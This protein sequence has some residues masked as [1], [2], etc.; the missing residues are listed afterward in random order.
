MEANKTN[1]FGRRESDFNSTIFMIARCSIK[2]QTCI[3]C[4]YRFFVVWVKNY[5]FLGNNT[6]P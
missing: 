2:L 3:Q 5:S 1:F 6:F 4:H